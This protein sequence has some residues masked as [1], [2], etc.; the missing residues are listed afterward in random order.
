MKRSLDVVFATCEGLPSGDPDD[1][2]TLSIL[3]AKGLSVAV[4]DWRTAPASRLDSRIVVLRSTWDYHHY[5][6]QFLDWVDIV[7][8]RTMLRN[9]APA[10][11]WNANKKYLL[12]LQRC[13]VPIVP[14][15]YFEPSVARTMDLSAVAAGL[16]SGELSGAD[17]IIVK[18]AVGLSTYGVKRF[19][20]GESQ[21]PDIWAHMASVA[22]SGGVLMQP[23]L[24]SVE[25]HGERS[26]VFIAN[27]FSHAVRKTAFQ[28]LAAAGEAG[29]TSVIAA[30]D[31]K[32]FGQDVLAKLKV[33]TGFEPLYA[34]VD[35]VRDESNQLMLLE[36]EL[37]EPSLFLAMDA[38]AANRFA[39]AIA[40]T[41][42]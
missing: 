41:L 38:G 23:Y 6:Q 40:T 25:N 7:A 31:E 4:I 24:T 21:I 16:S 27:Q 17:Q 20:K 9:V 11:H 8:S 42:D 13:G 10:V 37:I 34:R 19:E 1:L 35:V 39:E 12:Q 26:L 28:K 32:D 2:L 22:D 15:L 18:P 3:E 30:D 14:T 5:Y 29:E 36:L 33:L